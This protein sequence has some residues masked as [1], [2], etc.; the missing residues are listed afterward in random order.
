MPP[1]PS[2][3]PEGQ[4]GAALPGDNEPSGTGRRKLDLRWERY[5]ERERENVTVLRSPQHTGPITRA[6]FP[7]EKQAPNRQIQSAERGRRSQGRRSHASLFALS[8][9]SL[10]DPRSQQCPHN[11]VST[12]RSR[13]LQPNSRTRA[14]VIF[15]AME[16]SPAILIT[17]KAQ[18]FV[19]GSMLNACRLRS[20]LITHSQGRGVKERV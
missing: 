8:E 7:L 17:L 6:A 4:P 14:A 10:A 5:G 12:A 11:C 15:I 2:P 3:G 1:L 19:L 20:G 18:T 9:R 16:T 13:R